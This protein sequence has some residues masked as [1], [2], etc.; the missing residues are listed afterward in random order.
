MVRPANHTTCTHQLIRCSLRLMPHD[1]N[2]GGFFVCVLEKA[3]ELDEEEQIAATE[4]QP[5]AAEA[6]LVAA[7]GQA[8]AE[9][10]D[11][12][13]AQ[14]PEAGNSLKRAAPSS[15][16]GPSAESKPK[17]G[18]PAKRQRRDASFK[19]DPFSFVDPEHEE[20]KRISSVH[21]PSSSFI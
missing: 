5:A 18:P 14:E 10:A 9:A 4:A 6:D 21:S 12:S 13:N 2:T 3:A 11:T 1:Q 17:A 15:P 20:V 7:E 16:A 8:N 19:E